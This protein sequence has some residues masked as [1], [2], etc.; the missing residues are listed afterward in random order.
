MTDANMSGVTREHLVLGSGEMSVFPKEFI[1]VCIMS[2]DPF[3][4]STIGQFAI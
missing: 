3:L 2:A 1:V 4:Y